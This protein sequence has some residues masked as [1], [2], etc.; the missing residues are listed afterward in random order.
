MFK[1][2]KVYIYIIGLSY[3]VLFSTYIGEFNICKYL[4]KIKSVP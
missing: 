3:L 2:V 4:G 1:Q